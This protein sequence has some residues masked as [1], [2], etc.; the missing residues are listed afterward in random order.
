VE[1][2]A[3][4]FDF[5]RTLVNLG[6]YVDWLAARKSMVKIYLSNGVPARF[7]VQYN[8]PT[9]LF[10]A[11]SHFLPSIL[12]YDK[13]KDL[14]FKA[15]KA[16]EEYELKALKQ[17]VPMEGC[18]KV[19][20]WLN[21][22]NVKIGLISL[23]GAKVIEKAMKKIGIY[24]YVD[25]YFSRDSPGRPKPYEDHILGFLENFQISTK[26]SIMVGD[27]IIDI[28]AARN[29]GVFS[30][31]ISTG[32]FTE[33]ELIYQGADKIIKNLNELLPLIHNLRLD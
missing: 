21:K 17:V 23:N 22:E 14:Q 26:E 32:M 9:K 7:T 13:F 16:L 29:A 19:L 27:E 12:D 15:S 24:E 2:K 5:D 33:K 11:M 30:I 3:V 1:V 8:S 31:G 28:K 25:E 20:E 4:L 6:S 10:V 18:M